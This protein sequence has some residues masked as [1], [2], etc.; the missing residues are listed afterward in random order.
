MKFKSENLNVKNQKQK[1]WYVA[2]KKNHA[3]RANTGTLANE[4]SQ[5]ILLLI[6]YRIA[7]SNKL[8]FIL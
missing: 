2:K 7:F 4:C 3:V 5:S 1:N 8:T 6:K